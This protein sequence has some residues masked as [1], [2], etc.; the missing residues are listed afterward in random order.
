MLSGL[1]QALQGLAAC[2]SHLR[3]R[4]AWCA[5]AGRARG[6]RQWVCRVILMM[7]SVFASLL[8]CPTLAIYVPSRHRQCTSCHND[9]ELRS[10]L[11]KPAGGLRLGQRSGTGQSRC[12]V[13]GI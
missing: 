7:P 3:L 2:G 12:G 6:L 8:T 9:Y 11:L 5:P 13:H 1:M 10:A 4:E